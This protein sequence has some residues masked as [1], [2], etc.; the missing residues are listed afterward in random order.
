MSYGWYCVNREGSMS[1]HRS[2][3]IKVRSQPLAMLQLT[4]QQQKLTGV[5]Y[6]RPHPVMDTQGRHAHQISSAEKN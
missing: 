6:P 4:K 5:H 2:Q 1:L 3:R